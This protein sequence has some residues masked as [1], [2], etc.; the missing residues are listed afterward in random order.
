MALEKTLVFSHFPGVQ[1]EVNRAF[2][3]LCSHKQ[4][5]CYGSKLLL[6]LDFSFC[7]CILDCVYERQRHTEM[8]MHVSV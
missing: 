4:R 3:C 5:K 8:C 1:P 2:H 7:I 6:N